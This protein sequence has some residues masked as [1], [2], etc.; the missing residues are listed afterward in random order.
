[1]GEVIS[2]V[3]FTKQIQARDFVREGRGQMTYKDGD[4]YEGMWEEDRRNGRGKLHY[5]NGDYYE[6]EFVDD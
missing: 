3:M 1:M 6:G 2:P 5:S 4:V